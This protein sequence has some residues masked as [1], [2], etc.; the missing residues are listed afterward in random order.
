MKSHAAN[1]ENSDRLKGLHK[2]LSA[3]G[4]FTTAKLQTLTGSMAIHSDIH[5]LRQNGVPVSKAIYIGKNGEG[6]KVYGYQLL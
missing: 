2:A 4:I 6:K 5:E 3:G 1:L